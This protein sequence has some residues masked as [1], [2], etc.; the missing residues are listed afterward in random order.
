MIKWVVESME[1]IVL[2]MNI[3]IR[4]GVERILVELLVCAQQLNHTGFANVSTV[5]LPCSTLGNGDS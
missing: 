3:L 4:K 5:G 1:M 2:N